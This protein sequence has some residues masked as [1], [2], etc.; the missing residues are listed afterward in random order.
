MRPTP[1]S[2][3]VLLP[4]TAAARDSWRRMRASSFWSEE[5]RTVR[6][7]VMWFVT[8]SREADSCGVVR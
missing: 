6:E 1:P 7:V 8:R 3:E 4:R 2:A 5:G